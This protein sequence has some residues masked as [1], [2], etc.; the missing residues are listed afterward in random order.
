MHAYLLW[1]WGLGP[2]PDVWN[3]DYPSGGNCWSDY[4]G[5]DDNGDGI[6]D[7][8]YITGSFLDRYVEDRCMHAWN[9][10]NMRVRCY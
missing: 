4:N 9:N 5:T 1:L 8:P 10:G 6:G 7:T 3:D 2:P